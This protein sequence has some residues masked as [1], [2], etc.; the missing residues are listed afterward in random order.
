MPRKPTRQPRT[1][2]TTGKS[3]RPIT[4]SRRKR[5]FHQC[6][7]CGAAPIDPMFG[8]GLESW[9]PHCGEADGIDCREGQL[10]D[11]V[12]YG[13]WRQNQ[14]EKTSAPEL[15]AKDNDP[16]SH[17]QLTN[18]VTT[19][20]QTKTHTGTYCCPACYIEFNLVAEESLKCDRCN[21]PL[22]KGSLEDLWE[23]DEEHDEDQE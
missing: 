16:F 7:M 3:G 12:L 10:P 22:T 14:E 4:S 2:R 1:T 21:G 18:G 5:I 9:C 20:K 13:R 11:P 17:F 15:D 19:M 8:L 23:D 6:L